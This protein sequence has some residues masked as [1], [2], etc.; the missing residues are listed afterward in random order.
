MTRRVCCVC[1]RAIGPTTRAV[2]LFYRPGEVEV[3]VC[4]P[5]CLRRYNGE[6]DGGVPKAEA[7]A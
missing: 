2:F 7:E 4:G 1:G 6:G 5:R 3:W